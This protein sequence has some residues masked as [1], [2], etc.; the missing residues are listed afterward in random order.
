MMKKETKQ[1]KQV[2]EDGRDGS[3]FQD[4]RRLQ[5]KTRGAPTEENRLKNWRDKMIKKPKKV[6]CVAILDRGTIGFSR[7]FSFIKLMKCLCDAR[8]GILL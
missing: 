5:K 4:G 6:T 3:R 8:V 7:D 1:R 2:G